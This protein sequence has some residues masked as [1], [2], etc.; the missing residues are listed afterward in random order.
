MG[1]LE[2]ALLGVG[3]WFAINMGASGL[4]PAFGATMGAR[5]IS[6]REGCALRSK[7]ATAATTMPER[8]MPHCPALCASSAVTTG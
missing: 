8:Q 1:I 7:S 2:L 5:L 3:A 4:A 6:A